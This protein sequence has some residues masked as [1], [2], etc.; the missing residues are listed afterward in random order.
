MSRKTA[1]FI[2]ALIIASLS[3]TACQ[4]RY[5]ANRCADFRDIFQF[6]VGVTTEGAKTGVVPPSLGAYIQATEYLNLG[7]LGYSGQT[8]EWDGRGMFVGKERRVRLGLGPYQRLWIDQHYDSGSENYFK[9]LETK[10]NDRMNS[11]D[12]IGKH[13]ERPAKELNYD[14]WSMDMR[15]GSPI[16]HRGWQYWE[17]IGAEVCVSDPLLSH[18]GFT[19]RIGFDP[20]EIS[21][22]VLGWFCIDFKHDDLTEDEYEEMMGPQDVKSDFKPPSD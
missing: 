6:G 12:L 22:F 4:S 13:S 15:E 16:Y 19:F 1:S 10:W 2:P 18:L 20:S 21:D 7:A 9:K 3:L 11:P 17:N 5:L 14:M 8:A